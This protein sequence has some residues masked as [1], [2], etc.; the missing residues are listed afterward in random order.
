MK[1][2][3]NSRTTN[4]RAC[5]LIQYKKKNDINKNK[6]YVKHK[7]HDIYKSKSNVKLTP[8]L[9]LLHLHTNKSHIN[10]NTI[11]NT[12]YIKEQIPKRIRELVW[13]TYNG[14]IY[15]TKCFVSW[16]DNKI[17]VFNFQT[18][19]D[20]PESKGGTLDISNLKPICSSCN[21][22]MSNKYTITEWSKL[23]KPKPTITNNL[24]NN[25]SNN[26]S[27]NLSNNLSNQLLN[28]L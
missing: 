8:L 13:T 27:N 17:N 5:K 11:T 19:H 7:K 23:V 4:S 28:K 10:S 6:Q 20:I 18:G 1:L 25:L 26:I 14:E 15:T 22:S 9:P 12:N 24:S 21:L 3:T 2:N 16:C